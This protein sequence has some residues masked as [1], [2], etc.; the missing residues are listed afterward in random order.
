MYNN[1]K[2][3]N[4]LNQHVITNLIMAQNV[5][6]EYSNICG[7]ILMDIL[8]KNENHI[9]HCMHALIAKHTIFV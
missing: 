3:M 7:M 5:Y 4:L 9:H 6:V 1:L 8:S 2:S